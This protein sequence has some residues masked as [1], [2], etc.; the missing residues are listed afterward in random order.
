M[1]VEESKAAMRRSWKK[2]SPNKR[3]RR[4]QIV[5]TL[6]SLSAPR[7]LAQGVYE[8]ARH[9]F[10]KVVQC[11]KL[12]ATIIGHA[13]VFTVLAAIVLLMRSTAHTPSVSSSEFINSL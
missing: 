11:Y 9:K 12:T 13:I 4:T 7:V 2:D 6:N 1:R 3:A 5:T 10:W 8:S